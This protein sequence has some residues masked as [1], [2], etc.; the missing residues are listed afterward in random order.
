MAIAIKV[1][2][3]SKAYQLREIATGTLTMDLGRWFAKLRGKEH[4]FHKIGGTNDRCNSRNRRCRTE[5]KRFE[6]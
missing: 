3:L 6:F 2:N 4:A 1:E 5:L